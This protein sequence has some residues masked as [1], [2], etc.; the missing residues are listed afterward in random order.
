MSGSPAN[1]I[2][3]FVGAASTL[4]GGHRPEEVGEPEQR[5]QQTREQHRTS[6]NPEHGPPAPVGV[7]A[8]VAHHVS[9]F[10]VGADAGARIG[11][12]PNRG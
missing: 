4:V 12:H 2:Q 11:G 6:G 5:H 7:G 3:N 1:T 8:Y 10:V 9:P